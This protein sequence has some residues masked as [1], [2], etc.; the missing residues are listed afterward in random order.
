MA[1]LPNWTLRN[2]TQTR[3]RTETGDLSQVSGK[4]RSGSQ[5]P[6]PRASPRHSRS[7]WRQEKPEDGTPDAS[8]LDRGSRKS[9]IEKQLAKKASSLLLLPEVDFPKED[10]ILFDSEATVAFVFATLSSFKALLHE[11]TVGALLEEF[12][13]RLVDLI[14]PPAAHVRLPVEF[15]ILDSI[16]DERLKNFYHVDSILKEPDMADLD[17]YIFVPTQQSKRFLALTNVLHRSQSSLLLFGPSGSGKSVLLSQMIAQLPLRETPPALPSTYASFCGKV[18]PTSGF[19]ARAELLYMSTAHWIQPGLWER[20]LQS[21]TR[22]SKDGLRPRLYS[23]CVFVVDDC[24]CAPDHLREAWRFK[25]ERG[26]VHFPGAAGTNPNAR[27]ALAGKRAGPKQRFERE[28]TMPSLQHVEGVMMVMAARISELASR[29]NFL[30]HT[31]LYNLDP[32]QES[33][34]LKIIGENMSHFIFVKDVGSSIA[35]NKMLY[36]RFL[37][38]LQLKLQETEAS[39]RLITPHV[40]FR[41]FKSLLSQ[42][43]ECLCDLQPAEF[44]KFFLHE[45]L[46]ETL[47][48]LPSQRRRAAGMEV[49][50]VQQS[51]FGGLDREGELQAQGV[52]DNASEESHEESASEICDVLQALQYTSLEP[53]GDLSRAQKVRRNGYGEI[54]DL[55]ELHH[56]LRLEL[57]KALTSQVSPS[58]ANA[59]GAS[60]HDQSDLEPSNVISDE[61]INHIFTLGRLFELSAGAGRNKVWGRQGGKVMV[62]APNIP[63]A[64]C[65][66]RGTA[67]LFGLSFEMPT[68]R[69]PSEG[70]DSGAIQTPMHLSD[71]EAVP[72]GDAFRDWIKERLL[73]A[74]TELSAGVVLCLPPEVLN[75]QENLAVLHEAFSE[76]GPPSS[77]YSEREVKECKDAVA[78]MPIEGRLLAH[79]ALEDED[80]E[81]PATLEV[82]WAEALGRAH[83][84]LLLS[85]EV[86]EAVD[87]RISSL[88]T[89]VSTLDSW[90]PQLLQMAVMQMQPSVDAHT[91]TVKVQL[92]S[93]MDLES[94]QSAA[95]VK[96][97]QDPVVLVGEAA[98][99]PPGGMAPRVPRSTHAPMNVLDPTLINP[100]SSAWDGEALYAALHPQRG[101]GDV[102]DMLTLAQGLRCF[103]G[104][105]IAMLKDTQSLLFHLHESAALTGSAELRGRLLEIT[106]TFNE[107]QSAYEEKKVE[108]EASQRELTSLFNEVV[109]RCTQQA[110]AVEAAEDLI[111]RSKQEVESGRVQ[112][113]N[114][115][116]QD[117]VE[118]RKV[119]NQQLANEEHT[120]TL[121]LM[122]LCCMMMRVSS[123][124]TRDEIR[125]TLSEP[126]FATKLE[127]F[128]AVDDAESFPEAFVEP[129]KEAV[130]A[131]EGMDAMDVKALTV[132]ASVALAAYRYTTTVLKLPD[133]K[134]E[135]I[136][137]EE[138]RE[139]R[140]PEIEALQEQTQ[141]LS[142]EA[143]LL[144]ANAQE[145]EEV[146][147]LLTHWQKDKSSHKA[148]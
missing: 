41:F 15:S 108:L 38:A 85:N 107:A 121:A 36:V 28:P 74:V 68:G 56:A 40:L 122:E 116:K 9:S 136:D 62:L 79:L 135:L 64:L 34:L 2:E 12:T 20:C 134:A 22:S 95:P 84:L 54:A 113:L 73:A 60:D 94:S 141:I 143:K 114:F 92:F 32:L 19:G 111:I 106:R 105:D 90:C 100:Q 14:G 133:L 98:N 53:T 145:L 78:A 50:M 129:M 110:S 124:P 67:H 144:E 26:L 104:Q 5:R 31:W 72:S 49:A 140:Q 30:R 27:K 147:I 77:W 132:L 16:P 82:F 65:V 76:E 35:S 103:K 131:A 39:S 139:R 109:N 101:L 47:D 58:F 112:L 138:Q 4:S 137:L 123:T 75:Q 80:G 130:A 18:S 146:A 71:G 24:H 48:R 117:G 115:T 142:G 120:P 1:T 37:H 89:S 99:E 7:A 70:T 42:P 66:I 119:M 126:D 88:Y 51:I 69:P 81:S 63:A 83:F 29:H 125:N 87:S 17:A 23:W 10:M 43:T 86:P 44:H 128:C 3:A 13:L 25:L 46:R 33:D 61:Y 118:L 91:S 11:N 96:A 55:E 8:P 57:D 127:P 45:L 148:S 97:D 52:S 21:L 102:G 6:S 93:P 59:W